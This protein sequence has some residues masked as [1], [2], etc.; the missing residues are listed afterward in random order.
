MST[1]G[2][3]RELDLNSSEEKEAEIS[4][5]SKKVIRSPTQKKETKNTGEG[6][7]GDLKEIKDLISTLRDDIKN[8]T[9]ENQKLREEMIK[10]EEKWETEKKHLIKRIDQLENKFEAM[11]K[12]KRKCRLVIKGAKFKEEHKQEETKQFLAEKL[13]VEAEVKSVIIL[14]GKNGTN[15]NLVEM[16]DWENKQIVMKNKYKLRGTNVYIDNDMTPKERG[17]QAEIRKISREERSKGNRTR[18]G[19]KK[20]TIEGVD[21]VWDEEE[22]GVVEQ[23]KN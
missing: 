22:N 13:G 1:G 5:K 11:E 14:Q 12:E 20:I 19:Y 6:K 17:I 7:M 10:R 23:T 3:K 2:L 21:F 4:R 15:A 9:E 8:N 16:K 18:I